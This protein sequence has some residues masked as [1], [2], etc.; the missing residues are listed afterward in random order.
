MWCTLTLIS[1]CGQLNRFRLDIFIEYSVDSKIGQFHQPATVNQTVTRSQLS[2]ESKFR[3][4]KVFQSL[5]NIT[6]SISSPTF[7]YFENL[8]DIFDDGRLEDVI[9]RDFVIEDDVLQTSFR[10]EIPENSHLTLVWV[11]SQANERIQIVMLHVFQL[12]S[13]FYKVCKA[14]HY[15]Q[16]PLWEAEEPV[17][18]LLQPCLLSPLN[19]SLQLDSLDTEL[20]IFL[21]MNSYWVYFTHR[22]WW[23]GFR[24]LQLLRF[25]HFRPKF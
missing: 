2:M 21:N 4:M 1:C 6:N 23:I 18:P 13:M 3:C 10:A 12:E 15:I 8:L 24:H 11:E 20:K 9:Q 25:L 17:A 22:L 7:S 19:P 16:A 14:V 5:Q